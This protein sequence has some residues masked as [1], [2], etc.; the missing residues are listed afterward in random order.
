[1]LAAEEAL[2]EQARGAG[3]VQAANGPL[4]GEPDP[5]VS[6]R[7]GKGNLNQPEAIEAEREQMPRV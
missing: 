2:L 6:S 4:G 1:M 3:S 5:E 7:S